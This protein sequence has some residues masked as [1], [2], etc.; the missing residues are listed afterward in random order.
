MEALGNG[1][2]A[3]VLITAAGRR[4]TLVR[5]FG[6]AAHTR[7]GRVFAGD[8]D[9]LAPALLL[10][11]V[12]VRTHRTDDPGYVSDLLRAVA[13]HS[14]SLVVPTIDPD[15]SVLADRQDLFVALGCRVAVSSPSF[16]R[17]AL[18]KHET[19]VTF[20][21]SGI[22]VPMTWLPAA[23]AQNEFS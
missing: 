21:A 3:N 2:A 7:K 12:A 23:V 11:D 15:L 22:A 13:E 17:I 14:I 6:D 4:T 9:A 20:G 1:R 8:V 16:V 18:D 10:A 5:A 19:G